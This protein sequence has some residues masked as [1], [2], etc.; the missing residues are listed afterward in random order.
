MRC[1]C[2]WICLIMLRWTLIFHGRCLY[3]NETYVT[4]CCV[5]QIDHSPVWGQRDPVH[6]IFTGHTAVMWKCPKTCDT[7]H[8]SRATTNQYASAT[9][10]SP[11]TNRSTS[12]SA[13]SGRSGSV[14]SASVTHHSTRPR[15]PGQ[16]CRP[17]CLT[18]SRRNRDIS[19]WNYPRNAS[20]KT[21][22]CLSTW[23]RLAVSRTRFA[24]LKKAR[25]LAVLTPGDLCGSSLTSTPT[26]RLWSL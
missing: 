3:P 15:L 25:C 7:R 26:L 8:V 22:C 6:C 17:V 23:R 12:R 19:R 18:V 20:S 14:S 5:F 13:T 1:V 21:K 11:S 10:Q 2:D 4:L 16:S 24:V 9:D